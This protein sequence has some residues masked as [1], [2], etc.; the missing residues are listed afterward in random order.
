MQQ[1]YGVVD[2]PLPAKEFTYG[3]PTE[4]SE[5]AQNIIRAGQKDRVGNY[6]N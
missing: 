1:H 5:G 4:K 3:V 6:I 2:D